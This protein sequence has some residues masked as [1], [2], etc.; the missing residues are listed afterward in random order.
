MR[1]IGKGVKEFKEASKS[2][3]KPASDTEK[4]ATDKETPKE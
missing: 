4:K 3:D 1:G 2:D